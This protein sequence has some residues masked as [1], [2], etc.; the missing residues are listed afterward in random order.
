MAATLV[1]SVFD[2]DCAVVV[3]AVGDDGNCVVDAEAEVL[4]VSGASGALS[5][6]AASGSS[7]GRSGTIVNSARVSL[8]IRSFSS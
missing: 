2:R 4:G 8:D 7:D 5:S 3:V 6:S 1:R